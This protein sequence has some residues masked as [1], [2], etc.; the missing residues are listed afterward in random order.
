MSPQPSSFD[1]RRKALENAFFHKRDEQLLQ[2]FRERMERLD[3]KTKLVEATGIQDES[4]V[5]RLVDLQIQPETLS[6][7]TLVPLV[8]IA[9]ADGTV[10]AKQRHAVLTAAER[11]GLSPESDGHRLLERW[12]DEKPGPELLQVWK[13][14]VHFLSARIGQAAAQAM[15]DDILDRAWFVAEAA[16]GVFGFHKVAREERA[17]LEELTALLEELAA[18]FN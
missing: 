14:Y 12:L 10:H 11:A 17:K 3:R 5:D 8:E 18:A 16:R 9:W 7:L 15:R 2:Q 4:L 13:D 1:E 6:A